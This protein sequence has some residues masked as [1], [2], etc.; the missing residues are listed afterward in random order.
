MNLR[1]TF[2]NLPHM[3]QH[4]C[5]ELKIGQD[6]IIRRFFSFILYGF[7][8]F[9][10]G[11]LFPEPLNIEVKA[12]SAILINADTGAILFEK[13]GRKQQF[14]ASITKIATCFYTLQQFEDKLDVEVTAEAEA[15]STVTDVA[16]RKSRYTLPAWWLETSSSHIGLKKGEVLTLEDLLYGMMIA[17]GNDAS[18]VIA[19]FISGTIPLFMEEVNLFL[20]K[21]GCTDTHFCNPHGLHHP[22][23]VTTAY[24]MALMTKEAL[25]NSNFRKI[26]KT[27]RYT[28][29]KTNKQPSSVLLQTNKLLRKDKKQFYY[30]KAIGVKTG[31]TSDAQNT[32]VA[33]A[34]KDGRCLIA[35]LLKTKER[36]DIF[37]DAKKLFE[38]AFSQPKL[39]KTLL[40]SGSQKGLLLKGA[41][42]TLI[43]YIQ[44]DVKME[45]YPA[46]E[47]NLSCKMHLK[48]DLFPPIEK[49]SVIG[50]IQILNK[51]EVSLLS[52]PVYAKERVD[53]SLS[54]SVKNFFFSRKSKEDKVASSLSLITFF[55][56]LL[57]LSLMI[58]IPLGLYSLY[59]K[60]NS[61]T[62]NLG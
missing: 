46:E 10:P 38:A 57:S 4:S 40:K 44:K 16:K 12:D 17:S 11:A 13:N 32:L 2:V 28:K 58:G 22:K 55:K 27:S 1:L 34:E 54:S 42:Q 21:L 37:I 52:V 43:P 18:N 15:I 39:Q 56:W 24:D 6:W 14:P 41:K 48:K 47:P 49:G 29:P 7:L 35:V 8:T 45:Y 26:V 33:A 23:H 59:K 3:K 53:L 19:Q 51:G 61:P 5:H 50:E 25:K 31:F 60:S 20:K 9:F 62:R 30:P 36:D